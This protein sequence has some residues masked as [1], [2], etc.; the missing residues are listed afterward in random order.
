MHYCHVP[1]T[2]GEH[3]RAVPIP[4]FTNTSST[5]Y[6]HWNYLQV[7]LLIL[8]ELLTVLLE[9]INLF[10]GLHFYRE[11]FSIEE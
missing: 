1:Q 8:L 7:Q 9:Y 2:T 5:K 4:L 6:L 11:N 10:L 3:F